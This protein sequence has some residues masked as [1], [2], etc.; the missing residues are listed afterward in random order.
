[1]STEVTD[2]LHDDVLRLGSQRSVHRTNRV[3][4]LTFGCLAFVGSVIL[5]VISFVL[6]NGPAADD[7]DTGWLLL[8]YALPLAT[9]GAFL[10]WWW[11]VG[12]ERGAILFK[13]GVVVLQRDGTRIVP[14]EDI[15]AVWYELTRVAV[16]GIP[17]TLSHTYTLDLRDGERIKLTG[18]E[19][20]DQ[21]GGEVQSATAEFLIPKFAAAWMAGQVVEFGPIH[22]RPDGI[23]HGRNLL[24]WKFVDSVQVNEGMVQ[25]KKEGAWFDWASVSV[26]SVPN[27]HV[28]V[29]LA[30]IIFE[31]LAADKP[32][33]PEADEPLDY[34]T[35]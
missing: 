20:I 1:M 18:V 3:F 24:P 15:A 12:R 33:R 28:I 21:L 32:N 10:A 14:F 9:L 25:V 19:R 2:E 29:P 35:D 17:V 8:S 26:A 5:L 30:R 23:R 13:N 22:F 4:A 11:W 7:R 27:F 6:V 16:E 31:K 34:L